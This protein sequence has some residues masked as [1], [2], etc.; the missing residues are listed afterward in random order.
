MKV[1]LIGEA[2]GVCDVGCRRARAKE[3]AGAREVHVRVTSPP[4]IDPCYLGVD[5]PP[6]AEL[7]AAII[8]N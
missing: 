5:L 6:R 2:D 4:I 7:I 8:L 3:R 1:A